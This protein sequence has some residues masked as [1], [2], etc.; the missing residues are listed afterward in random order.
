MRNPSAPSISM[1]S[2]VNIGAKPWAAG[3]VSLIGAGKRVRRTRE[4]PVDV[5]SID[6]R[7]T[8]ATLAGQTYE[9]ETGIADHRHAGVG[10]EGHDFPRG[11][12]I[13]ELLRLRF[14]GVVVK[15]I[16][17]SRNPEV[18]QELARVPRVLAQDQVGRLQR[19]D[20]ARRKVAEVAERRSDDEELAGHG[21]RVYR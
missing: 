12:A 8:Q 13:G 19:L 1:R 16:G 15:A 5:M 10:N 21:L 11:D 20:R 3:V 2:T 9:A 17:R 7:V 6:M 18:C 4:S 14:L